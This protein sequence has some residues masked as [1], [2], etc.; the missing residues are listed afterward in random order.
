M[1]CY[2]DIRCDLYTNTVLSG[3][4]T[5]F[6][7]IDVRLTQ[8]ITALAPARIKENIVYGLVVAFYHHYLHFKKCGIDIKCF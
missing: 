7:A 8:E 5:M 1:K 4:E 3:G 2:V 6:P